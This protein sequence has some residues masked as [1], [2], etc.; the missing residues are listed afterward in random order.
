[1]PLAIAPGEQAREA[2]PALRAALTG[3]G[4]AVLPYAAGSPPPEAPAGAVPDTGTA[5]VVGTSGS[6]GTPKLAML[7][8]SSLAASAAATHERLGGPGD[9]L[10]AMPPHH[11]AGVQVLLRCLAAG[12]EPHFTDLR[13]GFTPTALTRAVTA[14]ARQAADRG[15][16]RRY[17]AVVPTQL[18]RCLADP[19]ATAALAELDAVLVGGA[20]TA[21]SVLTR[22]RDAGIRAVTTYG[23]SE[24]CGGCV[25]DGIALRGSSVRTDGDGRISLGG[26]TLATGYLGRP[27][28]TGQAFT[29]DPD[30]TRWFRTDDVGHL[31]DAGHWHVDGRIDDLVNTGGLKVAPRVVE[32]ALTAHLP[33]VT[34]A[35]VVGVPDPEWG[36][37]VAAALTLTDG[38]PAPAVTDVRAALR[39]ILPD[40]ALPRHLLVLDTIPGRGPGKPDRAAIAAAFRATMEP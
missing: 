27:D 24:T 32:E 2:L 16:H 34:E 33:V 40:H 10:L 23:M 7:P 9:W 12:T 1:M 30:G 17:T 14:M 11:I 29:T 20:A 36:Q 37:A 3:T 35:V 38:A 26:A 8:A 13:D 18:V 5:L 15:S 22:A 39:G 19:A 6:T 4:P 25:Y 28:L 21:P 31:D